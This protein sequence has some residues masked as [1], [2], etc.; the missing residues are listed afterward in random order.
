MAKKTELDVLRRY[1]EEV[2]RFAG[3]LRQSQ[4]SIRELERDE[5]VKKQAHEDARKA[6]R[7]AEEVEHA[8]VSMLLRFI[9][10][11]S[12]DVL[13][14]FDT[15]QP[16]DERKQGIGAKQW[17]KDPIAV[18]GLSA[19]AMRALMAAD[20]VLVGQLQDLLLADPEAWYAELAEIT[21]GMAE[22]IAA[23]FHAYVEEK[24]E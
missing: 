11:G 8:T 23:K 18:L 19:A 2:D 7:E 5:A 9:T 13:P 1:V 21:P 16:A 10:P 22:A 6:R 4:E 24:S 15:M 20:I 3:L 12:T 14:L 17:R